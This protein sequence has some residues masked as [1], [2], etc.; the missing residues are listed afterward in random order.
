VPAWYR[1][2]PPELAPKR[3]SPATLR[4]VDAMGHYLAEV[5]LRNVPGAAWGI[6]KLP[7]R[8][9]YAHQNKPVVKLDDEQDVDTIGIAYGGAVK[10][11]LM[12]E[13]TEPDAL[14][15]VYRAWV[16]G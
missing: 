14:L 7:K 4:D 15:N 9:R 10:V 3:L 6:A 1:P 8:M 11:A 2:D 16:P 12:G 5:F 13:G